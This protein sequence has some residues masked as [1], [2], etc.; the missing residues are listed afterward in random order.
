MPGRQCCDVQ[1]AVYYRSTYLQLRCILATPPAQCLSLRPCLEP[2]PLGGVPLLKPEG[3]VF[4]ELLAGLPLARFSLP[5][6]RAKDFARA[7]CLVR[8]LVLTLLLQ[9][10][11]CLFL[12]C[13]RRLVA[14]LLAAMRLQ[15]RFLD[16]GV[17]DVQVLRTHGGGREG[18]RWR[19]GE[20]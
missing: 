4:H 12:L 2:S 1:C 11:S 15:Q 9:P 18:R 16:A 13:L 17:C 19:S 3:C 8:M 14:L 10:L 7:G 20:R 5:A 6:P